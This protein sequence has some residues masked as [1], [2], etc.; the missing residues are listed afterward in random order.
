MK[1]VSLIDVSYA[2]MRIFEKNFN[3]HLLENGKEFE[4]K[5]FKSTSLFVPS[6]VGRVCVAAEHLERNNYDLYLISHMA[7]TYN[8]NI[9]EETLEFGCN[10]KQL[11]P[12]ELT[13]DEEG[14][15][16]LLNIIEQNI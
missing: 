5:L 4:L 12:D 8:K 9:I 1:R 16:S 7:R 13:P 15:K 3:K 2:A 14:Y 10:V 6:A 11:G